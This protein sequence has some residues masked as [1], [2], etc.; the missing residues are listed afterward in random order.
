MIPIKLIQAFNAVRHFRMGLP[1]S[2]G[3]EIATACN[4]R[5]YYCPVSVA[6]MK[7]QIIDEKMWELFKFRLQE[8]G[9]KGMVGM[10]RYN[11]LSLVPNSSRYVEELHKL[12]VMPQI[13]TNGDKPEVIR[14]WCRAGAKRIEVTQHP[15]SKPGWL[16]AVEAV[17][18]EFPRI[19]SVR[20]ITPDVMHNQGGYVE[21]SAKKKSHPCTAMM[22][23]TVDINGDALLCCLDYYRENKFGNIQD[24]SLAEIWY[25]K[26]Y[27][28]VRRK[29][30]ARQV[31]AA[32]CAGCSEL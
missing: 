3:I 9:W 17:R 1:T 27:A 31:G 30:R 19:I 10:A 28:D 21:V 25:A 18:Q 23:L 15:P 7:Q 6:P 32:I 5:C 26:E 29:I 2:L 20:S 11:E 13:P 4:R 22:G 16:E 14:E 24:K 12:G 8:L